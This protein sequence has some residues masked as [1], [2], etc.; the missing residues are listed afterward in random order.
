MTPA[1]L[2]WYYTKADI[3]FADLTL[4]QM[5][6]WMWTNIYSCILNQWMTDTTSCTFHTR[7]DMNHWFFSYKLKQALFI[8]HNEHYKLYISYQ[9]AVVYEAFFVLFLRTSHSDRW[10]AECGQISFLNQWMTDTT[11]CMFHTRVDMNHWFFLII[12][13]NKHLSWYES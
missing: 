12:N 13:F 6:S 9:C 3:V 5:T 7:V 1:L 8:F 11:S 4:W 2:G 10:Q